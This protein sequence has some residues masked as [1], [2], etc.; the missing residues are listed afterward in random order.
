VAAQLAASRVV[1]SSTEL[2]SYVLYI[3][4]YN[5]YRTHS[6][7]ALTIECAGESEMPAQDCADSCVLCRESSYFV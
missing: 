5:I 3:M 2:V 7:E 1:L 6:K 4:N